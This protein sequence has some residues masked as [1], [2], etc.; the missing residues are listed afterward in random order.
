MTGHPIKVIEPHSYEEP[1]RTGRAVVGGISEPS[2]RT[3]IR[4]IPLR[5]PVVRDG[6][7]RYILTA[8]LRPN[9]IGALLRGGGV[10]AAWIGGV[11]DRAGRIVARS[12]DAEIYIGRSANEHALTATLCSVIS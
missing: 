6:R 8:P 7:T 2:P 12:R 9:S 3:G 5:V 1:V 11:V 10:P 4:A